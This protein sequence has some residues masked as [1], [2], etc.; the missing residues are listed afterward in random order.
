MYKHIVVGGTFDGLHEGHKYFLTTASGRANH[1]TVGLTSEA[2]IRRFKPDGNVSSYSVRYRALTS[3]LRLHGFA[4]RATIVPLDNRWGPV[5]LPDTFDSIAVTSQNID[6]A[7]EINAI[8]TERGL[9]PLSL[10]SIDLIPSEDQKP[11]SS[12]RVRKGEIDAKGRLCMPDALRGE[13]QKLLGTIIPNQEIKERL[14]AHRDDII[15]TVGD[16]TT[17][18]V[19]YCGIQPSLAIIDLHVERKPYQT[20]EQWKFPK[21]YS[22]VHIQSGPGYISSEA[23]SSIKEWKQGVKQRLRVALIVSGEEDLLV[24]PAILASPIGSWVY[25]GS[26]PISGNEG[27]VEVKVTGKLKRVVNELISRF[28]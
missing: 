1:V 18:T 15:V 23:I 28:E 21:K 7:H 19:F 13:L 24:L 25:Y 9:P 16:V 22:I 3:W 2:Y 12:T 20:L 6:T 5:L 17:E 8:R 11:I 10:V 27:L 26:P 14:L 4:H